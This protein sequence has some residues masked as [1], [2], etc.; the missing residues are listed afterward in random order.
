MLDKHGLKCLYPTLLS[1]KGLEWLRGLKLGFVDDAVLKSL[2]AVL[3]S[4]DRQIGLVDAK[5]AALALTTKRL[6]F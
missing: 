6:S 2:L 4:L 1:G 5:I 3:E